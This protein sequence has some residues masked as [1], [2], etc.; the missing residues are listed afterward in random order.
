MA[1]TLS[2]RIRAAR[3]QRF[4]GRHDERAFFREA[5]E[6]EVLP[7]N[8]LNVYGPGGVGKTTLLREF[9]H[10]GREAGVPVY[11]LD[12]RDVE[13][14]PAALLEA[15]QRRTDHKLGTP[16][17]E[18][19]EERLVLLVDTFET[20]LP[21]ERWLRASFLPTLPAEVLLVLSGRH[22]L[23]PAWRTDLGLQDLTR[24]MPLR[25]LKTGESRRY[26]VQRGVPDE[27]VD[28]VLRFTYGH[29]MALSLV[30]DAF[31]R[32][33]D[34]DLAPEGLPDLIGTL[35]KRV[36]DD[37]PTPEHRT[38]IEASAL[39]RRTTEPLLAH[40]LNRED[41][42]ELFDWL[43]E[44]SF[45]E[46]GQDGILP[47]DLAREVIAAELRWRAPE[48]HRTLQR[49]ARR[50]YSEHLRTE[51][52]APHEQ[53]LS[54]Y[55]FLYR[56]NPVVRP[57]FQQLRAQ[58]EGQ[59]PLVR[60]AIRAG[61]WPAL[62]A[63]T[64]AHEGEA[65]AALLEYWKD[66]KAAAGEVVRGEDG[67]PVGFELHLDLRR[68]GA[69]ERER[70]PCVE[71]ACTYLEEKA[72]LR[73]EETAILFRY[74]MGHEAHQRVS[75]V[76]SLLAVQRVC[77]YLSTPG[78]AYSIVPCAE[79]HYWALLFAYADMQRLQDAD[80]EVGDRPLGLFGHD[81]RVTPPH[82]WL[83]LLAQRD[84]TQDEPE[85]VTASTA[86]D[87]LVLSE[88]DF[89]DAVKVLLEGY[90]RPEALHGNPLLR[91]R[92]VVEETG[93]EA[94]AGERADVLRRLVDEAAEALQA[95]PREAKYYRALHATYLDPAPT[96]ERAAEALQVPFST[97]RRHLRRG[98]DHVT[99]V[100]WRREM[101]E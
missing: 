92:L 34:L 9:E 94:D 22:P 16:N 36:M 20:M 39:V 19:P 37:V 61:D 55:L 30:A 1:P 66:H 8:V 64:T 101:G 63:M 2:D 100:L 23:P 50:Y 87:V 46:V 68:V 31:V 13:P 82:A 99:E 33:P 47:H 32:Q 86:M 77:T 18:G 57:F 65:S 27:R 26:L 72:P 49:R 5:L 42:R 28:D 15:I 67:T 48:Q 45:V 88:T 56:S 54:D 4:V 43:R 7:V 91:S 14:T 95:T 41:V 90:A 40:M 59:A 35:L 38:A 25:N 85:A 93:R 79:P 75:P 84:I 3:R 73:G 21:L 12:A 51:T 17:D 71:A 83:E 58:W 44:Q 70:D 78:L 62:Y 29:P 74:W 98:I 52:S 81:W 24:T 60:D 10:L 6:A 96:Q 97:F 69:D 76:Q 80:A 53:V 89:V 11:Y